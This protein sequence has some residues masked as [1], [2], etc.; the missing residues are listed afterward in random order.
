MSVFYI[1][2]LER[3]LTLK[4]PELQQNGY[5]NISDFFDKLTNVTDFLASG[6]QLLP[7]FSESS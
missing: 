2:A 5:S 7:F 3:I 4:L 1:S 6:N